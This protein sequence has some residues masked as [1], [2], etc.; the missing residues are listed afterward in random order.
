DQVN[1]YAI[2][3]GTKV[4]QA[5]QRCLL[6]PPVKLGP[7][8]CNQLLE[9]GQIRAIV[10]RSTRDLPWPAGAREALTQ[11]RQHFVWHVDGKRLYGHDDA[12][13][14]HSQSVIG[15]RPPSYLIYSWVSI[16]LSDLRACLANCS[17]N[18]RKVRR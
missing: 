4:R 1:A 8:I 7:P 17:V 11:V 14:A 16:S 3:G 6:R 18:I 13:Y 15:A 2:D 9:I 5:V 10:P 12:L